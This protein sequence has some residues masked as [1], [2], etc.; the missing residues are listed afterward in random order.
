MSEQ[1]NWEEQP[2]EEEIIEKAQDLAIDDYNLAKEAL[3][4]ELDPHWKPYLNR[5][6]QVF[7][8]NLEDKKAFIDHPIDMEYKITYAL[9][10]HNRIPH[11]N[12]Y[13]FT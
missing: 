12:E 1:V 6:G 10:Y 7:Y 11:F 13:K 4:K 5:H 2:T 3:L 9:K 8:I